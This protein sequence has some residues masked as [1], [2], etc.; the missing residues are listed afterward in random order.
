[1]TDKQ[2]SMFPG[3]GPAGTAAK[4][5]G[6]SLSRTLGA[7]PQKAIDQWLIPVFIGEW[8]LGPHVG[9]EEVLNL[10]N[11][12][13]RGGE[14]RFETRRDGRKIKY[15]GS[16]QELRIPQRLVFNWRVSSDRG[17]ESLVSVDF[18]EQNGKTRLRLQVKIPP[19]LAAQQDTLKDQWAARLD[20]LSA[21]LKGG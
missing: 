6:F 13:R 14:F 17:K 4:S 18:T 12:V 7:S 19:E 1:M 9:D 11:M 16:Y 2:L 20:A 8:M 10:Q 5:A 21:R 3:E 15:E